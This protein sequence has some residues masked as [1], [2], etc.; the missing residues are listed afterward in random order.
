MAID[1]GL[2]KIG[3]ALS[4]QSCIMGSPLC[5]IYN[6]KDKIKL[7]NKIKD[8]IDSNDV[9]LIVLG[10]PLN[11]DGSESK[12][13][14]NVRDFKIFLEEIFLGEIVLQNEFCTSFLAEEIL[15]EQNVKRED[16]KNK[17]DALAA[18]IILNEY[19]N[20]IKRS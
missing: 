10:L 8:L 7:K 17:V 14:E 1:Y 4:D 2:S 18:S 15:I 20:N 9:S 13:S 6:H 16:R 19:I 5:F 12:M 3:F 11:E